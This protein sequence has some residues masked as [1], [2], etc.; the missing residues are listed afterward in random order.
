MMLALSTSPNLSEKHDLE[1]IC[2]RA[3]NSYIL[4]EHVGP[5]W[6]LGRM[7]RWT[8]ALPTERLKAMEIREGGESLLRNTTVGLYKIQGD[9]VYS[10]MGGIFYQFV[11]EPVLRIVARLP[12]TSPGSTGW[13]RCAQSF[14]Y[15]V[16]TAPR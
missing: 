16:V 11:S 4:G 7:L 2:S 5:I 15:S 13:F 14:P 3:L 10:V 9:A 6:G 1:E 8:P 12:I